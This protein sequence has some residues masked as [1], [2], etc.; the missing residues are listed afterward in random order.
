MTKQIP[1]G[2][3]LFKAGEIAEK[4]DIQP[5]V[6][7][8]WE[9]EFS[10]H[11]KPI[12]LD[13]G[14]RLYRKGDLEVFAEIKR[15][16]RVERL[17][18]EGAKLRIAQGQVSRGSKLDAEGD[19]VAP[20]GPAAFGTSDVQT[21]PQATDAQAAPQTLGAQAATQAPGTQAAPLASAASAAREMPASLEEVP[22]AGPAPGPSLVPHEDGGGPGTSGD[23]GSAS[24]PDPAG[25]VVAKAPRRKAPAPKAAPRAAP[26]AGSDERA[27]RKLIGDVRMELFGLRE[28]MMLSPDRRPR[29][30]PRPVPRTR[31]KGKKA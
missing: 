26:D 18:V 6:V 10:K 30:G 13:S 16:L 23:A 8:H 3:L 28:F 24:L 2:Q 7:R 4:L 5:S 29:R 9:R 31:G 11:I 1:E 12:R 15:L 22:A 27:L 20:A 19:G 21:S 14:R 17:T 25:P